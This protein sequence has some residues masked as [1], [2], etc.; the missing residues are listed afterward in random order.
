MVEAGLCLDTLS[1]SHGMPASIIV[2]L[3]N[4][5]FLSSGERTGSWP[6]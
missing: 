6:R 2:F 4:I 1:I 3:E 5:E